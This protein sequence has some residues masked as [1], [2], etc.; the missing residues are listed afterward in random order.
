MLTEHTVRKKKYL[1]TDH[2]DHAEKNKKEKMHSFVFSEFIPNF[3]LRDVRSLPRIF[4]VFGVY[5]DFL[6]RDVLYGE[7]FCF[8]LFLIEIAAVAALHRND[9]LLSSNK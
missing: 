7:I 1:T 4:G 8:Y 3:L 2:A 6:V 9:N 5:P